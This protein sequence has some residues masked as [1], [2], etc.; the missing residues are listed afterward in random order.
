MVNKTTSFKKKGKRETSRRVAS[1]LPHLR[2]SPKLD[3]NLILSASTA[4]DLDTGSGTAPSTWQIRRLET[5]TK[6]YVIYML[7]MCTLLVLV[8]APGYLILVRLL[9]FVTRNRGC[10][11]D[12]D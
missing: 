5:S 10:R 4:R 8:V 12:G 7:L 1:K 11:I 6:V 9:I 3:L 2:R